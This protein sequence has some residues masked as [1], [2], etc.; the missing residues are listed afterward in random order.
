MRPGPLTDAQDPPA[1][2]YAAATRPAT[3]A[4][5]RLHGRGPG[6]EYQSAGLRYMTWIDQLGSADP[7]CA[8][9]GRLAAAVAAAPHHLRLRGVRVGLTGRQQMTASKEPKR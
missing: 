5:A 9:N 4:S 3:I 7:T 6:W 8:S 2:C 1:S